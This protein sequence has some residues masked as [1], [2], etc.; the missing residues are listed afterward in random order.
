MSDDQLKSQIHAAVDEGFDRPQRLQSAGP[1]WM[2][3]I[4]ILIEAWKVFQNRPKDGTD[5]KGKF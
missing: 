2:A 5:S 4:P 3:L 1:W